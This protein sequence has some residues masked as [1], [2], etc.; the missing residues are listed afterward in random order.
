MK[1]ND[2]K[3]MSDDELRSRVNELRLDMGIERRKIASTGVASKKGKMREM[4]R[5]VAQVLT[6]LRQRGAKL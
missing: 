5:S 6:I 1:I 4:R 2:V 3:K